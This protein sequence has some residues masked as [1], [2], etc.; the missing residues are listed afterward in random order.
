[1]A[2]SFL[3]HMRSPLSNGHVCADA[4]NN[5]TPTMKAKRKRPR[6]TAHQ[7]Q[8]KKE[9]PRINLDSSTLSLRQQLKEAKL[10]AEIKRQENSPSRPVVRTKFR[11]KKDD[12]IR[13]GSMRKKNDEELPDGKYEAVPDPVVYIDA[14]NIIG[15]WPRLRKWRDR[16]DLDTARR[17]LL[18]DVS[19]FSHI[20]GWDC[21]VVFDAQGTEEA[22]RSD[23]NAQNVEVVYTGS[24]T[25]D[26]YIERCVYEM[27][28]V[29]SRQVW[30]ATS[31]V[32]QLRFSC[33]KGAHVMSAQ[34]FVQEL[35]RVRKETSELMEEKN[36]WDARGKMLIATVD[37]ETRARLYQLR[38][39]LNA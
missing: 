38:D 10:N 25:A 24:E 39:E 12:T 13:S 29:G 35:K 17:L 19:E 8:N 32:A 31:D 36:E 5:R 9:P 15:A 1:M 34:L 33:S 7:K 22:M 20:R 27:C 21:V 23:V 2:T 6:P 26:S 16:S 28:E 11:R 4:Q 3:S 37:K 18:H 30:A 14:Y